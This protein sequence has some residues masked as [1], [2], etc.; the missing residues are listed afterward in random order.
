MKALRKLLDLPGADSGLL[1]E[2]A[3]ILGVARLAIVILP[4]RHIAPWLGVRQSATPTAPLPEAHARLVKRI[5]WAIHTAANHLP[6]Q[7]V[8]LPQAIVAKLMLRRRGFASTLYLGA[9]HD[10]AGFKAHAWIRAGDVI[11]TG[12]QDMQRYTVVSSFA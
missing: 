2:A 9:S 8:C 1:L 7:A 11:V 10:G 4:F 3:L 6:W 12:Y 5:G